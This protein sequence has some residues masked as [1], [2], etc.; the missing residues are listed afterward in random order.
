MPKHHYLDAAVTQQPAC[1]VEKK[2]E[3]AR[4]VNKLVPRPSTCSR[5]VWIAAFPDDKP[6]SAVSSKDFFRIIREAGFLFGNPQQT[7]FFCPR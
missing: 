4:V 7:S 2:K 6:E 3:K 1:F 5:L